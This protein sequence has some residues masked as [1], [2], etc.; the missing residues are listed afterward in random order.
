[1]SEKTKAAFSK[2]FLIAVVFVLGISILLFWELFTGFMPDTEKMFADIDQQLIAKREA[3]IKEFLPKATEGDTRAQTALGRLYGQRRTPEDDKEALTW[4]RKAAESGDAEA[5][6]LLA[7]H[8]ACG[9]GVERNPKE[10]AKWYLAA[11]EKGDVVS[12]YALAVMYQSG[13]GVD[14]NPEKAAYWQGK[15]SKAM[16]GCPG[17]DL[18]SGLCIYE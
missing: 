12:Q 14:K 7:G 9:E 5:Q 4:I 17:C 15:V 3:G 13:L 6:Y 8:Y 10:A 2:G 11:A 16:E 1:M 18:P